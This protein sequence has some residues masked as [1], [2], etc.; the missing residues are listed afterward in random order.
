MFSTYHRKVSENGGITD[1]NYITHPETFD[2]SYTENEIPTILEQ[3]WNRNNSLHLF[4]THKYSLGFYRK[5]KMTE[6]EIKARQ[7]AEQSRKDNETQR[8]DIRY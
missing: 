7:F 8:T 1:D 5:E 2:D 3:N 4:L 6:A